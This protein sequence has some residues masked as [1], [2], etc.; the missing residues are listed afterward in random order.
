M[1]LDD[2]VLSARDKIDR[3]A[4]RLSGRD[5]AAPRRPRFLVVQIDGLSHA[6]LQ[7][8]LSSGRMPFVRT[9]LNRGGGY[10]LEPMSVGL[11][12]STPAFQMAAMY[13]VRPDIPGFH[14]YDRDRA[15]DIHF[16]RPGHAAY[17]ESKQ[18]S[19]RSG[20]LA[21]GSVYGCC[22]TGGADNDLFSFAR[23]MQPNGRGVL[24]AFSPIV[25]VA[26]VTVKNS[27]LTVLELTKAVGRV[28]RHPV[29]GR[30]GWRW[31]TMKIGIS[32]WIRGYFTL[33]V[34]RDIY[35][36]TPAIYVNFVDYDVAAHAFAPRSRRAMLSLRRIDRSI[37]QLA[38]AM[39]RAPEHRYDL[40]ILA[41]HG[42]VACTPYMKVNTGCR[43]ERWIFDQF[44]HPAG[45]AQADP[46][47]QFNLARGMHA[48]RRGAVT[49]IQHYYNYL[50][51][52]FV[53]RL[54]SEAYQRDGIRVISA[55]PNALLYVLGAKEPLDEESLERRFPTLCESLSLSPGVGVV[56]ARS[57]NGAVCYWN[58]RRYEP[59]ATQPDPFA[60]RE[61]AVQVVQGIHDLMAMRSAGD[62]VVYGTDAPQG[63]VS[64][65]PEH[66]AH[67]GPSE[68]EMQ[69][70]IVH[71]KPIAMPLPITHPIQL[72]DHFIRYQ[73]AH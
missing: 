13:G 22:F 51:E 41:D 46:R 64:F 45:A 55:G 37:R 32:V 12:T 26:W 31:T 71:P 29:K 47:P 59:S 57:K 7:Q 17:V 68:D 19:G 38:R 53:R 16:P 62:V 8:A 5:H 14:Y 63:H 60:S 35:A 61:D 3:L 21:G 70:F 73:Q 66:G 58:G 44:L 40:Y 67:A 69:T 72:Y 6:A 33:A 25:V 52:D 39:R 4:H 24:R 10:R 56:L 54:D 43:F 48:Q 15:G 18:A 1:S 9:L 20:I 34:S 28:A 2:L 50:E 49:L 42:Q 23:L 27:A 30:D 65:L 11:P 36:G